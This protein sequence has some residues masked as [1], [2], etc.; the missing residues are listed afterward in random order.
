VPEP[1]LSRR[2][3]LPLLTC[4]GLG[5]IL[6]AGIYVLIGEV[7]A[8][9]GTVAPT[10]FVLAAVL[11]CFTALSFAE[12]SARIPK[13]AGP[14]EYV[15]AAFNR[16][17]L[18]QLLGWGIV[19]VGVI[20]GATMIRGFVGYLSVFMTAPDWLVI[21]VVTLLLTVVSAWG[22]V[23]SLIFAAVITVLETLGLVLVCVIAGDSLGRLPMEWPTL[24]P[25]VNAA[26]LAG[27]L[28]GAFVAFYAFIG[29]EDIVNMAEET[30]DVQRT[31][32]AAILLSLI[33]ATALY[34]AVATVATL[35]VPMD[36]LAGH[37]APLAL[38]VESR[39][40]RPELIAAI[41]LLAVIN[42]ALIQIVMAS[43]VLYGLATGGN[44]WRHF[45]R[46]DSRT[47]T[48]LVATLFV[49]TLLLVL[50]LG[51]SLG[52]LARTTSFVTLL[53]FTLVNAS[54]WQLKQR[55]VPHLAFST[56]RFVPAAGFLLCA[57]MLL[58]QTT[59]TI[60]S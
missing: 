24:I 34:V 40:L 50:T 23:E 39:G 4:Y 35:A 60:F 49:A 43:R 19:A 3:G 52:N 25:T 53:I 41:S 16:R 20:S 55:Q 54:L 31:L 14:A 26:S 38:I 30:K 29:F 6:G 51:F 17:R 58:F 57:G 48:P 21:V 2:I 47:R 27:V 42:G 59:V 5:T 18:S 46:V 13:S 32:P 1:K 36:Q 45:A 10:A 12:L 56:P 22:V 11:A 7:A 15:L 28:S 8:I 44:A 9:A 33:I 37:E